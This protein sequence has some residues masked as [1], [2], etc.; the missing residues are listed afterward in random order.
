MGLPH[1]LG[2]HVSQAVV[3]AQPAV[4]RV[5]LPWAFPGLLLHKQSFL[6]L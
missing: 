5:A 1:E 2:G 3:F 6:V 4:H